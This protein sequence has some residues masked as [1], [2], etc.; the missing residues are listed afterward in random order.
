MAL[1]DNDGQRTDSGRTSSGWNPAFN[2]YLLHIYTKMYKLFCHT[3]VT[4]KML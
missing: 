3:C 4:S 1:P 2:F